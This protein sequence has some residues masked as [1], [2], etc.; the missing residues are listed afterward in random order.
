[1]RRR[2]HRR[3]RLHRR[4]Q[5]HRA[6]LQRPHR[7]QPRRPGAARPRR[8]QQAVSA[9]PSASDARTPTTCASS[10]SSSLA[11]LRVEHASLLAVVVNRADP[12]DIDAI[13]AA[14]A[15]RS[16]PTDVPVWAIPE[17]PVLVAP[18]VGAILEAT[19][20]T[21]HQGRRGAARAR[22]AR[23][24]RRRDVDR[25]RAAPPRRGRRRRDP[26]RPHRRAARRA[27][28]QRL[29][30][31][32][33]ARR[34]RAQRRLRAVAEPI[35]RLIDGLG[36]SLPIITHRARHLRDRRAHH[37]HA[38][39]ARRRLAAASST[40][41]SRCSSRTSTATPCSSCCELN[42]SSVVTPLMFEYGLIERARSERT[43]HRAARGQRRPHPAGRRA[44]CS[45]AA[46]PTSRSSAS[47]VEVRARAIELGV[48]IAAADVVSPF[49]AVLRFKFAQELRRAARLQGQGGSHGRAG[50]RHRHRRLLLRH[51]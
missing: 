46:S 43:P 39:P 47:E 21:A 45:R 12:D 24:R 17:D 32:P 48:D 22:G 20:G 25:E 8:S 16:G 36:S 28:G 51:A 31:L 6:R 4:R 23:R 41:R 3:Q 9:R 27:A 33:V 15:P 49:D 44:P 34:H 5:P 42:R 30:H 35:E 11:E 29:R 10:P 14:V 40:P 19:D 50:P 2:R 38:R 13:V 37:A 26:G 7:R 18:T 1:M